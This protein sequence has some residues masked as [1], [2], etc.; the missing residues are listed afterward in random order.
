M[1]RKGAFLITVILMGGATFAIGL[2]PTYA[3]AGLSRPALCRCAFQASR[4]A[5]NRRGGHVDTPRRT[6]GDAPPAGADFTAFGLFGALLVILVSRLVVPP[7]P[8]GR[9]GLAHPSCSP[10]CAVSWMRLK[11][12]EPGCPGGGAGPRPQ[13]A[14]GQWKNRKV[15]FRRSATL[16]G[17]RLV[18]YVLLHPTF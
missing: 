17:G 6:A 4:W 10:A 15:V 14:F 18:H 12:R 8:V 1:A 11:L 7:L 9:L 5:A 13:E 2:L 3:Q 16:S